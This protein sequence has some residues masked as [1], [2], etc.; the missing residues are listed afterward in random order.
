MVDVLD[1]SATW[2]MIV[3]SWITDKS[4]SKLCSSIVKASDRR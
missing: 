4:E 1:L 3:I 2:Y